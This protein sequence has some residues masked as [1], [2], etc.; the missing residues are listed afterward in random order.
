MAICCRSRDRC[1]RLA[2]RQLLLWH[3]VVSYFFGTFN[4]VPVQELDALK[5]AI[6]V[7]VPGIF[8]AILGGV[9]VVG[10]QALVSKD[11]EGTAPEFENPSS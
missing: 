11:D 4:N 7:L 3:L 8:G 10:L 2:R 1:E 6:A 9:G 5:M